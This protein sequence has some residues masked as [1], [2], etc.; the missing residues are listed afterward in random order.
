MQ[1]KKMIFSLGLTDSTRKILIMYIEFPT[2][3]LEKIPM[4][5]VRFYHISRF[6]MG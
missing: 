3:K 6:P 4:P 5:K 1:G 2:I